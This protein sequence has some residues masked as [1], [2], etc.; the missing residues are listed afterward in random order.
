MPFENA[1]PSPPPGSLAAPSIADALHLGLLVSA[2]ALGISRSSGFR[3]Q[4]YQDHFRSIK[5][6]LMR[7]SVLS[8][9]AKAECIEQHAAALHER[10]VKHRLP[11][12]EKNGVPYVSTRSAHNLVPSQAVDL[13]VSSLSSARNVE[14]DTATSRAGIHRP[15]GSDR[16]HFVLKTLSKLLSCGTNLS[17]GVR[18]PV[19]I[20]LIDPL[21][22][23]LGYSPDA[24]EVLNEIGDN[25]FYSGPD[26]D[27]EFVDVEGLIPGVYTLT[28]R[29]VGEGPYTAWL[30]V[31]SDHG[32]VVVSSE[33][34][35]EATPNTYLQLQT[36]V[37]SDVTIDLKPLNEDNVVNVS[38]KGV[39]PVAILSSDTLRP[40][41]DVK[42]SSL[43]FGRSG[44]ERSL[45]KCHPETDLDGDSLPDLLCHFKTSATDLRSSDAVAILRGETTGG[46]PIMGI[47]YIRVVPKEKR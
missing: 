15:C 7:Y 45:S 8:T 29:G 6:F 34:V 10:D 39:I 27:P 14:L 41:E 21:G 33:E 16:V 22:R 31:Y 19:D 12:N 44:Y 25:A 46:I 40:T 47:D 1:A 35:G 26:A 23:R 24:G 11:F 5:E 18:S 2:D 43:T 28:G 20:L 36:K 3:P 17:A 32:E 37:F 4:A 42:W 9:P 13:S 38:S 30:T